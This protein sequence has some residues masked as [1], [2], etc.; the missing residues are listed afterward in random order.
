MASPA[1]PPF[2]QRRPRLPVRVRLHDGGFLVDPTQLRTWP[3][4]QLEEPGR[5]FEDFWTAEQ[6][7]EQQR[8]EADELP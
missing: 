8:V 2:G 5:K 1:E 3:L 7:E 6:T 4:R